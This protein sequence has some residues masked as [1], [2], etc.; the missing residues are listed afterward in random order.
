MPCA[1]QRLVFR[2]VHHGQTPSFRGRLSVSDRVDRR[3]AFCFPT[4]DS[5]TQNGS[6]RRADTALSSWFT[7]SS[8]S[9]PRIT[10]FNTAS[11]NGRCGA[12]ASFRPACSFPTH[13]CR[14]GLPAN[15]VKMNLRQDGSSL[16]LQ[17]FAG[18]LRSMVPPTKGNAGNAPSGRETLECHYDLGRFSRQSPAP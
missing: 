12:F 10:V 15:H 2:G 5:L 11:S 17:L 1:C 14:D 6:Y 9:V 18:R 3:R 13:S 16:D 4:K 7:R 8:F